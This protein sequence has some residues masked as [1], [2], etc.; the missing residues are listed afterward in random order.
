VKT[1]S[2]TRTLIIGVLL[3]EFICALC[4]SAVALIHEMN[5]RRRAFDI[6]LHGRADSVLG[7]VQDA[8]DVNDNVMVD[9]TELVLPKEDIYEVTTPSG[10]VI[11]RS[12]NSSSDLINERGSHHSQGYFSFKM[13]GKYYRGLQ[14]PGV[15]VIDRDD[16]GGLRRPVTIVYASPTEHF[17]HDTV[18]AV[19]F[20]VIASAILLLL[21]GF[22]VAWF[23]RR[24]MSPLREL[25]IRAGRVSTAAWD[26]DVPVE[27][28]NT[29]E[30]QPI[31]VSIQNLLIGLRRSFE[32]QRQFTGDAAH[33]L[34]T[35]IAVLKSSLQVLSIR[36]RTTQEYES[37]IEG[38]LIDTQRME[39]LTNRMLTLA[40][41]EQASLDE[42]GVSDLSEILR[43]VATRLQ[44]AMHLRQIR[45]NIPELDQRLAK[46]DPADA[47]VLVSNLLI[48]AVQHSAPNTAIEMGLR[49]AGERVELLICDEGA[50]IPAEALPHVFERFYRA[51]PSRSRSNGG[52]GLGLAICKAITDHCSGSISIE[53]QPGKG[54]TVK[55]VLLGTT[56]SPSSSARTNPPNS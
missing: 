1:R 54:T 35:S 50:G 55:V 6:M 47:D 56:K 26:F 21:T 36:E 8:E 5:G 53:S 43:L 51:D 45:I 25:A 29:R 19:R 41:V 2:L 4:F 48:N 13:D 12:P 28:L 27:A 23:L 17:W 20:Y 14:V 52:A 46:I 15:R 44:P 24:A 49:S 10:R 22:V 33:E 7:A 30:L 3:A 40:R 16:H 31:A 42:M 18:V 37:S 34:K 9:Q 11:S 32:R 39:D 38:L